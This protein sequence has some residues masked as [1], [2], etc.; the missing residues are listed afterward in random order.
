MN[1]LP[2]ASLFR[3]YDIRGIFGKTLNEAD[4][5]A[6]GQAFASHVIDTVNCRTPQIVLMRDG[7]HSSPALALAMREGM[8]SA[9]ATVLDAGIG[10]TPMC[11]FATHFLAADGSVMVT[12]SHNPKDHNGAKFTCS[13]ASVHGDALRALRSRIETQQLTRGRGHSE[14]VNIHEEYIA[15]LKKALPI[16]LDLHDLNIVWDAGNG[17]AGEI[18][19]MLTKDDDTDALTL[20]TTIDGNFPHHHPDPSDPKN[21]LDLQKAVRSR[22]ALM[23]LAFDGD[24]DRLGVVDER[25]KMISP[26]HLLMLFAKDVLSRKKDATIIADVKTTDAFFKQV[27]AWGG[28]PLM[29]KTG[30]ALIKDKMRETNAAFAGEASGHI[31]FADEYYGYDDALY[32]AMRLI[33]IVAESK[34]PLSALVEALP[35]LHSSDEWRISI[36]DS[37]KFGIIESLAAMLMKDGAS[38]N[39]LDGVRVTNEYGWWLIRASNTD[40]KLV[41]RCEGYTAE[42]LQRQRSALAD[43]LGRH[44]IGLPA[45]A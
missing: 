6:I 23:G 38:V 8:A 13:G 19:D 10:P 40:A 33:R 41:A 29:W 18:I 34:R 12:G 1:T 2:D 16:G 28:H 30:H 36:D 26:D 15:E 9:G 4:F 22:T 5:Y 14:E 17:A 42:G 24:G 21:L 20:F 7:R 35:I 3:A 32:A 44:K 11:Y 39:Q 31:F 25:G 37:K 27:A 43:Y 45:A